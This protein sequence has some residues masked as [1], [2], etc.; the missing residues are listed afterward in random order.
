VRTIR[1]VGVV[2]FGIDD[3]TDAAGT[4]DALRQDLR[5]VNIITRP[6]DEQTGPIDAVPCD[7]PAPGV[8]LMY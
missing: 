2:A 6:V 5:L 7:Q 8:S 3:E 1:R 4:A